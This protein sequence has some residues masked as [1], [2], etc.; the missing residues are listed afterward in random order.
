MLEQ[1]LISE[2]VTEYVPAGK[3]PNDVD[4][5]PVF[6]ITLYGGCPPDIEMVTEPSEYPK[7]E[8]LCC[9]EI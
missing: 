2:T 7:H 6:H 4:V 3:L 1:L 8:T 5:S 9:S